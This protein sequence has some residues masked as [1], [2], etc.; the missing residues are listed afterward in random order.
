MQRWHLHFLGGRENS[1]SRSFAAL[2][3][4][5]SDSRPELTCFLPRSEP[6]SRLVFTA[7]IRAAHKTTRAIHARPRLPPSA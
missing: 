7:R 2:R 1:A 5:S 3:E 4:L 6:L